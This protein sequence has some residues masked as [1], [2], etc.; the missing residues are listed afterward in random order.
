MKLREHDVLVSYLILY[1]ASRLSSLSHYVQ[2]TIHQKHKLQQRSINS[3]HGAHKAFSRSTL[4][5][6]SCRNTSKDLQLH[7]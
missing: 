7:I 4:A 6:F 1:S 2:C 3:Y 5:Y